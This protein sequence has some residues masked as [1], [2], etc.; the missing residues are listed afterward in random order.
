MNITSHIIDY[1]KESLTVENLQAL[2]PGTG[3]RYLLAIITPFNNTYVAKRWLRKL[4]RKV[5][6]V[7]KIIRF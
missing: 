2:P 4:P 3:C 5:S 7:E 6:S 1:C